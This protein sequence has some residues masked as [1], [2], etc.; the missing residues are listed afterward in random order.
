MKIKGPP[1]LLITLFSS[2]IMTAC[3]TSLVEIEVNET[4]FGDDWPFH[5]IS[6][7][8]VICDPPGVVF[9]SGNSKYALNGFAQ[10]RH[11]YPFPYEV[12]IVKEV[13]LSPDDPN[14]G[15]IF[16]DSEPLR[17]LCDS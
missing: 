12:G 17:K 15:T 1:L 6:E 5:S 3:T 10:T 14:M 8:T 2:L 9:T 13:D 16:A 7:G 4:M 11:G